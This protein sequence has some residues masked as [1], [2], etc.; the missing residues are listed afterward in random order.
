MLDGI[1]MHPMRKSASTKKYVLTNDNTKYDMY[2]NEDIRPLS[3]DGS[4]PNL[5]DFTNERKVKK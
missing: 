3:N 1:R 2:M 4:L 5:T